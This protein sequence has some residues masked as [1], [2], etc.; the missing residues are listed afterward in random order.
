MGFRSSL[1]SHDN[2][3]LFVVSVVSITHSLSFLRPLFSDPQVL[4]MNGLLVSLTLSGLSSCTTPTRWLLSFLVCSHL[5]REQLLSNR[6]ISSNAYI[7]SSFAPFSNSKFKLYSSHLFFC[8]RSSVLNG[9]SR[10]LV[11]ARFT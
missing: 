3:N 8:S 5:L 10:S 9:I 7:D 2:S 6:M 4:T 1:G 11:Y